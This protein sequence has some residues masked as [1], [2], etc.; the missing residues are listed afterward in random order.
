M[1]H[2]DG[3]SRFRV[4]PPRYQDR[5]GTPRSYVAQKLLSDRERASDVVLR[6]GSMFVVGYLV[7]IRVWDSGLR[8]LLSGFVSRRWEVCRG[9]PD[10]FSDQPSNVLSDASELKAARTIRF[11]HLCDA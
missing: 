3:G 5:I 11:R 10:R 4:S 9:V 1:I 7:Y 8:C 6:G 2:G